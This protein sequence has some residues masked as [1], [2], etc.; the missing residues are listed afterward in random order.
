L[1]VGKDISGTQFIVGK[2]FGMRR[3]DLVSY[4]RWGK[5]RA[6]ENVEGGERG[7]LGTMVTR[8]WEE[9]EADV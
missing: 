8:Q 9:M 7:V 2:D 6:V 1:K 4:A 3:G 5:C